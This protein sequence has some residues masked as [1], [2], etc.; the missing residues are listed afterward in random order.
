MRQKFAA[1]L[2]LT[3][4]SCRKQMVF[5]RYQRIFGESGVPDDPFSTHEE[6]I[7]KRSSGAS[8]LST[9]AYDGTNFWIGDYSGT[10]HA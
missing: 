2:F 7:A 3:L 4:W 5:S 10:N 6:A 1:Q 9:I 8:A